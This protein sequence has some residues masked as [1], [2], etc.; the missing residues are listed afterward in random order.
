M[1]NTEVSLK[2]ILLLDNAT[3]GT[4]GG[5]LSYTFAVYSDS[6]L[7]QLVASISGIPE[8]TT[9]N[10]TH[11]QVIDP[12]IADSIV[13]SDT[14]KYWWRAR[15]N[16]GVF[17]GA[18][19][20]AETFTASSQVPLAVEEAVDA[21]V[22]KTHALSQNFPNPFNPSTRIQFALPKPGL[23][24]ITIYN[25]LGQEV[26]QLVNDQS[27]ATG[28][29]H[30]TWDGRNGASQSTSS[31]VYLYRIEVKDAASQQR[32]FQQAKKMLLI[33]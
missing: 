14:V 10:P 25:V 21:N 12:A 19:T 13:L 33:K 17:D 7:T 4:S 9:T 24:S 16:N 6:A 23:V 26:R 27:Y 18:W 3:P 2:P 1:S 8:G 30:V 5:T 11:W 28:F 31:G 29:H 22:P 20:A 32:V 15:A